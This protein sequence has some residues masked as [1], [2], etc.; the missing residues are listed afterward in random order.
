MNVNHSESDSV[1]KEVLELA[2]KQCSNTITVEELARLEQ[3]LLDSP[4]MRNR[5]LEYV[6]LNADLMWLYRTGENLPVAANS[7]GDGER[8]SARLSLPQV[9]SRFGDADRKRMSSIGYRQVVAG[10]AVAALFL[11]LIAAPWPRRSVES[12]PGSQQAIDRSG[13][14]SQVPASAFIATLLDASTAV[15]TESG[16]AIDAGARIGPGE[17]WLDS[18]YAELLFDTGAKLVLSGPARMNL[19]SSLSAHLESGKIVANM[20]ASAVGFRLSTTA[21][22]FIDQGTE[23]GVVAEHGGPSEVH[24]F[25]GQVDVRTKRTPESVELFSRE[26]MRIESAQ[27]TGKAIEFSRAPFDGLDQRV[28]SP[29]HWAVKDGGNG[30]FYQ[31][32][33]KRKPV[34]WHEAALDAMGR[35]YHGLPGHLVTVTSREE[36][37]FLTQ[38]VMNE[39]ST[40]G[41]WIGLTDVLRESDFRWVTGEPVE[42]ENWATYP[43]QQPD[44]YQEADWHGGE[45]YGMYTAFV[46]HQPWA[47]NDLSVDSMHEKVSAYLIEYERPID[48]LKHRSM[49]LEPMCW[50]TSDGGNG[51]HYQLVMSLESVD[52]ETVRRRARDSMLKDSMG[53]L[54]CLE[55]EG[56]RDFVVQNILRVSGIPENMIGL[57][58][59]LGS[60]LKWVTGQALGSIEFGKPFLPAGQVYGLLFWD[61]Q[62]SSWGIQTRDME[63]LPAGWFGYVVEY[64]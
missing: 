56:E 10:L 16:G 40:R 32:I 2:S 44:N 13:E 15:W 17:I 28:A 1:T 9:S 26:A 41:I 54:A 21:A 42:F 63:S 5:Y 64:P 12:V 37:Q 60:E 8:Q 19:Q 6:R 34:T 14:L 57:A 27:E 43:E 18:G 35:Y 30:H 3:I 62:A 39:T 48:A 47:W 36:D 33:V 58:G 53:H 31:L 55:T 50:E 25:R 7:E 49:A 51:H 61:H 59:G 38:S 20:P 24:V 11:V 4:D 29:I 23:F 22:D 45:D 46:G 52:W